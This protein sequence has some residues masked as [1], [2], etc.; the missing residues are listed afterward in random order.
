MI[1][2]ERHVAFELAD[3]VPAKILY[4]RR[5]PIRLDSVEP[6]AAIADLITIVLAALFSGWLYSL[7]IA[8]SSV[9]LSG[10]A[11]PAVLVSALFILIMKMRG[12]YKPDELLALRKQI[13]TACAAW[14]SV[15]LLL[16]VTIP[17]LALSD[18]ISRDAAAAFIVIGFGAL[19]IQ[20]GL[21]TDLVKRGLLEQRFADRNVVLLTCQLQRRDNTAL[22]ERLS[23]LG[24]TVQRHFTLSGWRPHHCERVISNVIDYVRG[25]DVEEIIIEA[26]P[27]CWPD[28]RPAIAALR[29]LPI[30]VSLI[31]TGT[32]SDIFR[33]PTRELG[34]AVCIELQRGPL[35][36]AEQA[37]KRCIDVVVAGIALVALMPLFIM[38]AIAIKLDS[39]GPI[40]FNQQRCGFNGRY[41]KIRKFRTMFVLEDG[42]SIHQAQLAD[43]RFTRLGAWL[44]RTS[45]DELP[46]LINVLD[47]TMS[48]I[49]PRP[50][51]IAHDNQFHK[52]V[53]NYAFRR[54]VKPGLTGWAQI[55]GCRGPTPTLESIEKRV[56]YDL[57]YIDNW[58]FLLDLAILLQTP[59]EVLRGRNAY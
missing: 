29:V 10:Y 57:W 2:A 3:Q 50:H 53:Q 23:E 14:I 43:K 34:D 4:G 52:I 16:F 54:R 37:L 19:T 6:L 42:P 48:L 33:H 47:G 55:K 21:I 22:T 13:R 28:L 41:F 59:I 27:S 49:G 11:G 56:G 8:A 58:S 35:T 1:P 46:Q 25:S 51:A 17:N 15:I 38:V 31:P 20:R 7:K 24:F 18:P 30:P 32:T 45:I 26:D 44:R 5:W 12:M 9:D 40:L 36:T 39:P